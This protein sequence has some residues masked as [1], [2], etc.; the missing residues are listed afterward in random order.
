V[1][2]DNSLVHYGKDPLSGFLRL[3]VSAFHDNNNKL[4]SDVNAHATPVMK[5]RVK[6]FRL[7]GNSG[8]E[9]AA[10]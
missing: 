3:S 4:G 7:E 5:L 10:L 2:L 1:S 9:L 6:T 8:T